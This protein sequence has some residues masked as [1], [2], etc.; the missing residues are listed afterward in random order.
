MTRQR[1]SALLSFLRGGRTPNRHDCQKKRFL[2]PRA[3]PEVERLEDR[4]LPSVSGYV[5]RAL[6][7]DSNQGVTPPDTIEIGRAHV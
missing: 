2:T 5:Y 1:W 4:T 3:R 7:Y 6:N